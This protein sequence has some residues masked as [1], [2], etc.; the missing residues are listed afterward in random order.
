MEVGVTPEALADE[1]ADFAGAA[2]EAS[3][4]V[5][6]GAGVSAGKAGNPHNAKTTNH[7]ANALAPTM[8][9]TLFDP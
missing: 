9:T 4:G 7:A 6:D 1:V 3:G 5:E 2:V 8:A